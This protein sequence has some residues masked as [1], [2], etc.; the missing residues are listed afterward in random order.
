VNT[1]TSWGTPDIDTSESAA[2]ARDAADSLAHFREHFFVPPG[3]IYLDGNSLGLL[4]REA[5]E[6][7]LRA[8]QQWKE[9]AIDGWLAADPPWFTLGEELGALTAPLLGAEP[10]SVIVTGSTTV[11]QHALLASFYQPYGTCRKIVATELDFPSDIYAIQSQ[12][13]LHGGDPADD[14]VRV[15][16][17][18]GRTIDEDD[19][20][21]ALT[22]EVALAILPAVLYRS[23]QLLDMPRLAAAARERGILLGFDCAH[24][25]GAVPHQFDAWG[26]DFAFWCSYKYLNAG[27]GATGGLYVNRKH[28]QTGP[29]LAGWWGSHKERQFDMRHQFEG[30]ESAGA[31]QISTPSLLATAPLRGALR[32]F[33]RAGLETLR[34]KSLAQTAYLADLLSAS[35][36]TAAPYDFT[37]GTPAAPEQRGGHLAVEHPEASRIS[38]TLRARGILPDFRAPNV[39]RLAP[40]PFST[41]YQELWQTAQ[42]LREIIDTGAHLQLAAGREL[43]A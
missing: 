8:L 25:A 38:R 41:T 39:I 42:A 4:S 14:L 33:H 30:A 26:V 37:L 21:A 3:V 1:T 15:T 9:L 19:I 28:W 16:S 36:L 43:V 32:L 34:A 20:I 18:D 40:V 29:G 12:I 24:S 13:A 11:N 6:E 35:G 27:P 22:D 2:L 10:E 31:W 17:R 23:G 5:E 7:T